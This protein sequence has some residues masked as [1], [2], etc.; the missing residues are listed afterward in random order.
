LEAAKAGGANSNTAPNACRMSCKSAACGDGVVDA[1]EACDTSG[2]ATAACDVD[3]TAPSCGDRVTN[4]A[5]GERCDDGNATSNDG[6]T[7][8]K[9]DAGWIVYVNATGG[10]KDQVTANLRI[11]PVTGGAPKNLVRLNSRVNNA[12]GVTGIG[13]SMPRWAP[14]TKPG[15]FWLAFSSVRAYSILRPQDDKMDQIWIG[16]VDTTA[17][18]PSYSGFWAP[19]QAMP[20]GNHRPFWAVVAGDK[21]CGCVDICG[22]GI[23]NDC[24]GVA[25]GPGCVTCG[26]VE[27]PNNGIDDNCDCVIDNVVACDPDDPSCT[28]K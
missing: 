1:G 4:V 5:A 24:N 9:I 16:A 28:V 2:A 18:D 19:F 25:D 15:V 21:N 27:I 20:E 26:P 13:N 8:C 6:C 17:A 12:D 7:A 22:D 23:D 14:S 10:S 11:V 3:C